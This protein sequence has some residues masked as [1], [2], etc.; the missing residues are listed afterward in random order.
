MTRRLATANRSRVSMRVTEIFGHGRCR[1]RPVKILHRYSLITVQNLVTVSRSVCAHV[2]GR[3]QYIFDT[4]VP[5]R[6]RI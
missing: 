1:G 4:L 6:I 3:P 2:E 5:R